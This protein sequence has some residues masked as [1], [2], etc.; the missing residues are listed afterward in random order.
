MNMSIEDS[1]F[2]AVMDIHNMVQDRRAKLGLRPT[3][4]IMSPAQH[5]LAIKLMFFKGRMVKRAGARGRKH[6]M[7]W[8]IK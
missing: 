7:N 4:L 3:Q 5:R 1:I 8:R 6:S 2:K